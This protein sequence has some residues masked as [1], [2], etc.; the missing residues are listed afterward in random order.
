MLAAIAPNKMGTATRLGSAILGWLADGTPGLRA[1][2]RDYNARMG[3]R[4]A[5]GG[6]V[7]ADE[8]EPSW[9]CMVE[10]GLF[11]C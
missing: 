3:H 9:F 5:S 2:W 1:Y 6:E 4:A 8:L 7:A 10:R 11:E